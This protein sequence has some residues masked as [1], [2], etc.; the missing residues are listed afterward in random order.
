MRDV[1]RRD[2]I[3]GVASFMLFSASKRS[4]AMAQISEITM[5]KAMQQPWVAPRQYIIASQPGET[6][7]QA[8]APR[9]PRTPM[10]QAKV[11]DQ[12][13]PR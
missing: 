11:T 12:A 1:Q 8:P 7:I 9:A 5:L 10:R 4:G 13:K 3:D 2:H 6:P